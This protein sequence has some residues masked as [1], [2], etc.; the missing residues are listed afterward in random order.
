MKSSIVFLLILLTYLLLPKVSGAHWVAGYVEDAL[1]GTSPNGR[2]VRLWNPSNG[3][4]I[5]GTVGPSGLSGTSNVYLMDCEMLT[6]SCEVGDKLNLTIVNDGSGYVSRNIVNITVTSGVDIADNLTINSPPS[7]VNL[8]FEDSFS[9]PLNEIDLTPAT[10]TTTTC[11]GLIIDLDG[12]SDIFNHSSKVYASTSSWEN[13]DDNNLHYTNNSCIINYSYGNSSTA[14]ITCGFYLEYYA[15][16]D[17]W[18]C[19]INITDNFTA[20]TIFSDNSFINPLLSIG[21]AEFISW[22]DTGAPNMSSEVS[23]EVINYGNVKIN[24]SLLG[25]GQTEG[26]GLAMVC[27]AE[28]ISIENL[29]Y[30]LTSSNTSQMNLAQSENYY[31]NMTTVQTNAEFKLSHRQSDITNDA[32]NDT[33]WRMYVPTGTGSPCQGYIKMGATQN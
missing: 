4:E 7:F 23:T 11:S 12:E 16:S 33:Y 31:T 14:L 15:D 1:D 22:T 6:T 10:N 2:T 5:F 13:P 20:S 8:T 21:V 32:K 27:P 30:N 17:T 24:L 19:Q 25:Y 18:T 26:D 9:T 28:N 29:K 3:Q